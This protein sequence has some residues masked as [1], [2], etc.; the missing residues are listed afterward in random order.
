MPDVG[1]HPPDLATRIREAILALE[2]LP[3]NLGAKDAA[4][5]TGLQRLAMMGFSFAIA[6]AFPLFRKVESAPEGWSVVPMSRVGPGRDKSQLWY[7]LLDGE[8]RRRGTVFYYEGSFGIA[9]TPAAA[10]L[11][12]L[13]RFTINRRIGTAS[14]PVGVEICDAA[15]PVR[16]F[17]ELPDLVATDF[18]SSGEF[19]TAMGARHT[20]IK[21]AWDE[22]VAWLAAAAPDHADDLA[23]WDSDFTLPEQET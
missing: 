1:R 7:W 15:R 4:D 5:R 22:A 18:R 20:E 16:R 19:H 14:C 11:A 10:H 9:G 12:L 21:R 23:Y 3:D 17:C 8:K 13:P 6:R 2:V